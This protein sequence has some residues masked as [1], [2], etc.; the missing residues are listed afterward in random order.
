MKKSQSHS[1][2]RAFARLGLTSR[3]ALTLAVGAV[4]IVFA[5]RVD[6]PG[7]A[8]IGALVFA[9]ALTLLGAPL[10]EPPVWVRSLARVL[11]GLS[12]GA[13][14]T[15][16]TVQAIARAFVPI[17]LMILAMMALGLLIA[18]TIRRFTDMPRVTACCGSSPG[19]L[20]AMVVLADEMGGEGAVVASMHLVR[21]VSVQ[22]AV[23]FFVRA[24]FGV[25]GAGAVGTAGANASAPEGALLRVVALL[26]VGLAAAYLANRKR[27]PGG[28]MLAGMLVAALLNP[29]WLRLPTT[30]DTWRLFAA[31]FIGA[32]VGATLTR[33]VLRDFRPYALSGVL[34]TLCLIA[35][36]LGLGW[37]LAEVTGLD[38]ITTVVG[39]SPGGADTMV[40]LATE[41]GADAQVVAAMHVSRLIM[42]MLLMPVL[43]RLVSGGSGREEERGG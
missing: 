13:K 43:I 37:V 15:T 4:G 36:G 23:P 22:L 25:D 40:L 27:I 9:G 8:L 35:A 11:L 33:Q 12:I 1:W 21:Y 2:H 31:W 19:G 3:V 34:M 28:E 29:L 24:R 30:P 7:G 32:G 6:L 14:V 16:E 17:V 38:I 42:I 5:Q 39:S 41:L 10:E 26:V 20:T 18:R